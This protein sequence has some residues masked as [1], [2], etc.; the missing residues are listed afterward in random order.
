MPRNILNY[1]IRLETESIHISL[2]IGKRVLGWWAKI[3]KMT[4][5]R[6]PKTLYKRLIAIDKL[7]QNNRIFLEDLGYENI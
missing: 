7:E 3:L 4:N 6:H 1:Y 2:E 5:D